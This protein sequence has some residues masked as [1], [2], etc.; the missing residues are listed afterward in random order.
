MDKNKRPLSIIA[1][2]LVLLLLVKGAAAEE[3]SA[4]K[5]EYREVMGLL[6]SARNHYMNNAYLDSYLEYIKGQELLTGY[7]EKYDSGES[8]R[9]ISYIEG[10]LQILREMDIEKLE[11]SAEAESVL[12]EMRRDEEYREQRRRQQEQQ[13]RMEQ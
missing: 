4:R 7:Q 5:E 13:M 6:E 2:M 10:Q 8:A 11:E 9:K 12:E 1:S 3:Y